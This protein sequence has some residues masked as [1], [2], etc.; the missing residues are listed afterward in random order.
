MTVAVILVDVQSTI[1]EIPVCL[2]RV[3]DPPAMVRL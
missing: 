3:G 1:G 2:D